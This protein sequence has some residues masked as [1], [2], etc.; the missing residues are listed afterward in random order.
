MTAQ[1]ARAPYRG[2]PGPGTPLHEPHAALLIDFDNV[3]MGIRSD[4]TKELKNLLNSDIIK[5]KVAVQRAYADWRR[6]PQYIVPLAESSVDLI[7][8]PAYGSAKKNATDIRLAIDAVELVFTRPE[9]GTIILLSGDSDFSSLVLKLKE[10][11]K[12]VI[13]VGIRESASDLL[14]QNCDEYYSY[15]ALT[16]LTRAGDE[17]PVVS[18]DPWELVEMALRQMIDNNDVMRSDRLKQVL[19]EMD[20]GF[21][22]KTLGFQKFNKFLQDAANRGI[23]SLR[24][25]ENGQYEVG[26]PSAEA[27]EAAADAAR[28]DVREVRPRRGR[29]GRGRREDREPRTETR[30]EVGTGPRDE[31]GTGSRDEA[32]TGPR[33]EAGTGSDGQTAERAAQ[34]DGLA[35]EPLEQPIVAM[36]TVELTEAAPEPAAF[37]TEAVAPAAAASAEPAA[38]RSRSRGRQA[39]ADT[40]AAQPAGVARRGAEQVEPGTARPDG[41]AEVPRRAEQAAT[42]AGETPAA[43]DG[44]G[45]AAAYDL[46]RRA[47]TDLV[48]RSGTAARD[49]DVKRRMLELQAG[50]DEAAL[51]FS[52]FSRFLRQAH[53]EEVVSLRRGDGGNY[54]VVAGNAD[55]PLADESQD[56][57]GGRDRARG[58]P[59]RQARST[60]ERDAQWPSD[61]SASAAR[62]D[63]EAPAPVAAE[64]ARTHVA[65]SPIA[66]VSTKEVVGATQATAPAADLSPDDTPTGTAATLPRP[67]QGAVGF[68]R[69]S[70]GRPAASGPPPLLAGQAAPVSRMAADQPTTPPQSPSQQE[71]ARSQAAQ[72]QA[73]TPDAAKETTDKRAPARRKRPGSKTTAEAP[74]KAAEA[75]TK[76]AEAP[77]KAAQPAAKQAEAPEKAAEAPEKAAQPA[78]KQA[79]APAHAAAGGSRKPAKKAQEPGGFDPTALGLPRNAG[80]VATYIATTYS[81]IGPK[82]VEALIQRFGGSKVFDALENRPD[83][84]REVMGSARG[85]RLLAAW[86]K[87]V[88]A[89]RRASGASGGKVAAGGKVASGGK[90]VKSIPQAAVSPDA[91]AARE[92]Q[93]GADKPRASRGRR[94]GRRQRRGQPTES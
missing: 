43:G 31:A 87:D 41:G 58:G 69:G 51:G 70:R 23:I 77:E 61:S 10:Y 17:P 7:F 63:A 66:A 6:Y 22:E 81:G 46:L 16:G 62:S 76:A 74:A 12:Y 25:Q 4:L 53:D 13:G 28:G 57:R 5:G 42:A 65:A 75:R 30:D 37:E 83:Q 35:A 85:D 47:T 27:M 72:P 18:E 1:F 36:E 20:P 94:G 73:E 9:I 39:A 56:S 55:V 8:A 49:S 48:R 33:D 68:R 93:S 59:G 86:A 91:P 44:G 52:K 3:T 19:L 29:R 88:R 54:D 89:R 50:W 79:E 45:L 34:S 26:P 78:A 32:G 38:R 14:V 71:P 60:S 82:S 84:V 15:S 64:A 11:G 90:G 40:A 24:K 92:E 2:R 80:D 21:D 67:V